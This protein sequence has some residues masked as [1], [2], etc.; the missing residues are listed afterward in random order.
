MI[1]KPMFTSIPVTLYKCTFTEQGL[2]IVDVPISNYK[3]AKLE[4]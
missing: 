1:D 2:T 4:F 3:V